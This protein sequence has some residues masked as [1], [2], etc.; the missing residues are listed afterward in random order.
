MLGQSMMKRL[1]LLAAGL[2]LVSDQIHAAN[3]GNPTGENVQFSL[4]LPAR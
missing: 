1:T 3:L 2:F 4:C